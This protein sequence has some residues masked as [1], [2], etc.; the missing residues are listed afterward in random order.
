MQFFIFR[1]LFIKIFDGPKNCLLLDK[2][3]TGQLVAIS[4]LVFCKFS[5]EFV[6]AIANHS[7]VVSLY[8]KYKHLQ[9]ALYELNEQIPKVSDF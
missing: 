8:P 3:K 2:L 9:D 7:T 5:Q 4:N 1:L 6:E